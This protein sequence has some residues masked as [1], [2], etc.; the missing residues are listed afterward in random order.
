MQAARFFGGPREVPQSAGA[1]RKT[2]EWGKWYENPVAW[3]GKGGKS[4]YGVTVSWTEGEHT[5]R[6]K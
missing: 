3:T 4:S 5:S 1:G 6:M 2:T